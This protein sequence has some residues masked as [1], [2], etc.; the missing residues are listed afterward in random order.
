[1]K[2]TKIVFGSVLVMALLFSSVSEAAW[3]NRFVGGDDEQ[4]S[5]E[6]HSPRGKEMKGRMGMEKKGKRV[7][8]EDRKEKKG[9][10]K[11]KDSSMRSMERY[12]IE[13]LEELLSDS[14][15]E[16]P[17]NWDVM[18]R[19]ERMEFLKENGIE[20]PNKDEDMEPGERLKKILEEAGIEIPDGWEDM[21]PEEH[22]EFF[23]EKGLDMPKMDEEMGRDDSRMRGRWNAMEKQIRNFLRKAEKGKDFKKFTGQLKERKKF[24]DEDK[25][26]SPDAVAF[27]QRRGI[28]EG[29]D[30][31]TF[32]VDKSINRAESLKVL[33]E[34]LGIDPEE[35]DESNFGDVEVSAW[36]AKYVEEGRRRGIVKGY[37]D[38]SFKPA[39]T[40]NQAEL[41]KISFESF[42]IDLTDYVVTDLPEGADEEAWYAKYLQYALDN[43]LLD[44]E[45]IDLSAGMTREMFAEVVSRL[46]Q[47]QEELMDN[48]G[49]EDGSDMSNDSGEDDSDEALDDDSDD[50]SVVGGDTSVDTDSEVDIEEADNTDSNADEGEEEET[51]KE[52]ETEVE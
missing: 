28:M 3:W 52:T 7:D 4:I 42:G 47:Q 37:K 6:Q 11:D 16:T 51:N 20:L 27:M 24:K 23:E 48:S 41:L 31:G 39:A 40:V 26:R 9:V 46:I 5:E 12:D 38:G 1:M 21:S 33:L 14:D 2:K 18:S 43:D 34:A 25:M 10:M 22:R 13:K 30:D 50:D 49:D 36:Y 29:Y 8:D 19:E 15:I 35:V 32:G 44:E 45:D 17:D